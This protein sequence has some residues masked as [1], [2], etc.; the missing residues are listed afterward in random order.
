MRQPIISCV[1]LLG[2]LAGTLAVRADG[3]GPDQAAALAE[4]VARTYHQA[5]TYQGKAVFKA[6]QR[7]GRIT[8]TE[9]FDYRIALDRASG[10]FLLD[11]PD[12]QF[13]SDGK[14]LRLV[15]ASF[16]GRHLEL[17]APAK[18]DAK[19][20]QLALPGPL[21]SALDQPAMPDW[22]FLLADDPIA[23][24]AGAPATKLELTRD[25]QHPGISVLSFVDAH[26]GTWSLRVNTHTHLL[27][28]ATLEMPVPPAS[29]ETAAVS[30]TYVFPTTT[31]DQP[32]NPKDL[33]L[34]VS[35]SQAVSS[36]AALSGQGE[37]PLLGKDAPPLTLET[38]E[39]KPYKLQDDKSK[40]IILDFW[41][42]WC[43]PCR[44]SLPK[45]QEIRDWVL[46]KKLPVSIYAVNLQED[47]AQVKA[48]V[49][50]SKLTIPVLL[51]TAGKAGEAY[52]VSTIPH[53]VFISQGKVVRVDDGIPGNAQAMQ[54]HQKE[55][56][57]LLV[58]LT[59]Q[60]E[61]PAP[62]P[63]N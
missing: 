63:N 1:A 22:T 56:K 29:G 45:L 44:V 31:L 19:S 53:T 10:Q 12:F 25:A 7:N 42:T 33:A 4:A 9:S 38:L 61:T 55:I 8:R 60:A 36:L 34:D 20:L 3:P 46:Q 62:H 41:A 17:K 50:Q 26:G 28:A 47:P 21:R 35:Q 43:G 40:V 30:L 13:A 48:F 58:K 24:L 27:T 14:K 6:I 15:V 49:A 32:I 51:D 52:G 5:K 11:R 18:L 39:G 37:S 57:E 2:L 23:A 16:P 54:E 59:G